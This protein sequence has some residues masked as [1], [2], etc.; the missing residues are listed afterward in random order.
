MDAVMPVLDG[1][2]ACAR[3]QSLPPSRACP[4]IMMTA[5]ED[6]A[7]V[8]KAFA[9]GASDYITKS[10]GT[11]VLLSRIKHTV[12]TNEALRAARARSSGDALTGLLSRTAFYDLVAEEISSSEIGTA[13]VL[14]LDIDRFSSINHEYGYDVGD[15][16]LVEVAQ[17]LKRTIGTGHSIARFSGSDFAIFI[18]DT[19]DNAEAK[20]AAD[21]ISKAIAHPF[22]LNHHQIF[23][24]VTIGIATYPADAA[25]ADSLV[26]CASTAMAK[27]KKANTSIR[28]YQNSM[29]PGF[30]EKQMA[31]DELRRAIGNGEL[32]V[33]YQPVVATHSGLVDGMEALVRWNHPTRGMLLPADFIP[34]AV[35]TGLIIQLGEWVM[36]SAFEQLKKWHGRGWT[37]LKLSLNVSSQELVQPGF[38]DR[39][40]RLTAENGL[41]PS[42]IILDIS[43]I[44]LVEHIDCIGAVLADLNDCGI[45]IAVDDF[46]TGFTSMSYLKRL[47]IASIKIDRAFIR[48]VPRT[49]ED[50]SILASML[51]Q[52]RE[53]GF[54]VVAEGV[55]RKDQYLFLTEHGCSFVQGNLT[56]PVTDTARNEL[57]LSLHAHNAAIPEPP[58]S[59]ITIR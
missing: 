4:V 14:Y 48:D 42:S 3:I 57:L 33:L 21:A 41:T 8:E 52:A 32:T 26:K 10:S 20:S 30:T 15:Q 2:E 28:F 29:E 5:L 11:N 53:Y 38:S 54:A 56:G 55:E 44:T 16:L 24:P 6:E 23:A 46:G 51:R 50:S 40:R 18:A 17:R 58:P 47:P 25:D 39:I 12:E 31:K 34:T 49:R 1:F 13:A 9:A 45:G 19:P 59:I 37:T 35:E 36:S 43:E 22:V 7:A 27:A